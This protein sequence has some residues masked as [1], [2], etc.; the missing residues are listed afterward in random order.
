MSYSLALP[1][2]TDSSEFVRGVEVGRLWEQL[3]A[4]DAARQ[5]TIHVSNAEMAIRIGEA[6]GRRVEATEIDETWMTVRFEAA[7]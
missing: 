1:F 2:D 4:D 6:V 7:P 5:E 3:K